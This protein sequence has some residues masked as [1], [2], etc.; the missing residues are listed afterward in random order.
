MDSV[1][2]NLDSSPNCLFENQEC[3]NFKLYDNKRDDI[4]QQRSF[5]LKL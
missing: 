2:W 5:G 1:F 3:N 4:V